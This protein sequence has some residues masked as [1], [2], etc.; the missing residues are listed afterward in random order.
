M[1]ILET[2]DNIRVVSEDCM[3]QVYTMLRELT[4]TELEYFQNEVAIQYAKREI[5]KPDCDMMIYQ[6]KE[7]IRRKKAGI[8]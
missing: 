5:S 4:L 1:T 7:T 6:A 3:N 8:W 2:S